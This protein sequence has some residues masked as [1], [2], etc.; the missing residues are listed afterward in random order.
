MLQ[1][2]Q[3]ILLKSTNSTSFKII[4]EIQ[5]LWSGYGT[6]SR[7]ELS[8]GSIDQVVI[9]HVKFP[10]EVNHPRGWNSDISHQRKLKSYQVEK[11]WYQN[12]V[13]EPDDRC[14]MP[15]CYA[16]ENHKDEVFM[17][18]EDLDNAGYNKRVTSPEWND[19]VI[20]L[21][22][23][24]NFHA[25]YMGV[26]PIGI[27]EVGT[28]WHLAT[29]PDELEVLDDINLKDNASKID[30][31]L[32]ST[33]YQTL[34]HGDAKLANFCFSK[35][36][37]E[38]SAV[39]FQ[40]VGQGC[41]MKDLVYFVG[42]CFYEEDCA[43][44]ESQILEIYFNELK[45][46]L[47]IYQPEI[48]ANEVIEEWHSMFDVAWADF[49]R[50]MKGWS[51]SHWK[52]NSYSEVLTKRVLAKITSVLGKT[53]LLELQSLAEKTAKKAGELIQ[54]EKLKGFTT[55]HKSVGSSEASQI[56]TK[57][58][59]I[60]ERYIL[61]ALSASVDKFDLGVLTEE[62]I[63]NGSRFEKEYFWCIDPLD[64]T[65][66][67]TQGKPG[68]A[69]S[70][71]LVT[72]AGVSVLG[73][74]YDPVEDNLYSAVKGLGATKNGDEL[75]KS[76][77]HSS[78]FTL[79]I[80]KSFSSSLDRTSVLSKFQE[81]HNEVEEKYIGGAVLNALWIIENQPSTYFKSV[82]SKQGG[83]SI[84]DF[85]STSC[86]VTEAGGIVADAKG[87]HLNLNLKG[88]AF[89]NDVGVSFG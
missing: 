87:N 77:V 79:V 6:I 88:S 13:G 50:F 85:A 82:K 35:N 4:E 34:V 14:R 62:Q 37:K 53:D 1:H 57:V 24:A 29:R 32:N 28:Y 48:K 73:V 64:G 45:L 19:I 39:D 69:V 11:N 55:E 26:N 78:K 46:A 33:K 84:W 70:I 21:K 80:D 27:W 25:K 30:Y 47:S 20:C 2:F 74:V 75:L 66:P 10:N 49:H 68:Y 86:I 42:S 67:F 41:G 38:V 3:D 58:D 23:L 7:Y 89:M 83:G 51:P 8:G 44:Y 15:K 59:R 63:D 61:K 9:K 72:K 18:L 43:K 65:L 54:E 81:K 17:V 36:G 56:V 12:F 16:I 31:I 22:W 5:S 76:K 60:V 40:Y 71:A 52:I